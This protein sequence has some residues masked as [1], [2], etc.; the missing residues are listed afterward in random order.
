MVSIKLRKINANDL[1]MIMKWRMSP[2]VTKYMYSEPVL[3]MQKQTQWFNKIELSE[4]DKY[5]II[6]IDDTPIGVLNLTNIDYKN[7]RS[8]W[9]Y[10]IGDTSFRGRGIARSLE[11]NIYDYVFYELELNKLCC[12]V[13]TFN[14]K[15]ISM[16]E[17]YGSEIEGTLKQHIQKNGMFYDIVK[18]GITR[19]K[20]ELIKGNYE[21][22]KIS[23]E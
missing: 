17:K 14:E 5:W 2:D 1:E 10:Y 23:I 3:D 4:S 8:D 21:Y 16:H 18:M 19:D 20:W 13:F 9:A 15:V 7:K 12:E 11:C 6:V 22:E